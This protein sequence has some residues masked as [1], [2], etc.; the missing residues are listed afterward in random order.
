MEM[1]QVYILCLGLVHE[2]KA[3]MPIFKSITIAF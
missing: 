2:E 3:S 1:P